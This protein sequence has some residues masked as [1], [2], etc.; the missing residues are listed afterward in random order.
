MKLSVIICTYN[1]RDEYLQRTLDGL[2][3]QDLHFGDWELIV[4][5]NASS[6][7]VADRFDL[8]WHPRGRHVR[9]D[10]LGLTPARLC[11]IRNAKADVLLFVDDDNVLDSDYLSTGLRIGIEYSWL[12]TWGGQQ[13]GE[14]EIEPPA[15]LLP[16]IEMLAIRKVSRI[17]W[18][19]MYQFSSTPVGAGMF[20]RTD[21][22][23]SYLVKA[24]SNTHMKGLDRKGSSL[25]SAGDIDMAW[26]AIDSGYGCGVFPELHLVHIISKGRLTEDY[27]LRLKYGIMFSGTIVEHLRGVENPFKPG[28]RVRRI[29]SKLFRKFYFDAFTYR[30]F[31]AERKARED[32]IRFIQKH[33]I[34]PEQ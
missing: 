16:Y 10:E 19:N 30:M 7:P 15:Q 2:R 23:K 3:A 25:A 5:D 20:I 4:V 28:S 33:G 14:F 1:P 11:G 9:E 17:Q 32:G 8:S 26:S 6:D 34:Q 29:F 13:T 22:A 18:S 21:I 31:Y 12:G 27:F 24:T